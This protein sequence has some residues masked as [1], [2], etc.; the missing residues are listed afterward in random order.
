MSDAKRRL[1]E[2]VRGNNFDDVVEVWTTM[3]ATP[4][5]SESY[6]YSYCDGD[7]MKKWAALQDAHR[8]TTANDPKGGP[9][10]EEGEAG[11][12]PKRCDG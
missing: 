1:L 5:E 2:I 10:C 12:A 9:C 4:P 11:E 8:V 7:A 6:R 3:P